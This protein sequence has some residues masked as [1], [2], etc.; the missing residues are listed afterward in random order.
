MISKEK[1]I[2]N[3]HIQ[4]IKCV[5]WDL[6]HTLW[7][8]VILE[9]KEVSLRCGIKEI[10]EQLDQRGI[11]QSIASKNDQKLVMEKLKELQIDQ[12]FLFPEI[13]WS[14]KSDSIKRIVKNLNIGIDTIAFID[15][16]EYE[17]EEVKYNL[18][19]VLCINAAKT[20][21][22]L[23][24]EEFIPRFI[25]VDSKKRRT[26]YIEDIKR[27][28]SEEEYAGPK[29]DFIKSLDMVLQLD[30]AEKS[31]LQRVEELT[32]RTNQLNATGTIYSYERLLTYCGSDSFMLLIASLQDKFGEYGKI[33]VSLIEI[34]DDVWILKMH[35]MSCRVMSRG[36]GTIILNHILSLAKEKGVRLLAEFIP[37]ERNRI[38]LLT[39]KMLHFVE[40]DRK[41]DTVILENYLDHITPTADYIKFYFNGDLVV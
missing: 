7:N 16:Q 20:E 19:Q 14:A 24:M 23:E 31:D 2:N 9:D 25:T 22:I 12:Y 41:D 13:C 11:L 8:G 37:N 39:Y 30:Y 1:L 3:D 36:V 33:G 6:D 5:V 35:L 32:I 27:K 10:I 38:M 40:I 28:K 29:I 26:M 21:R 15:D 34:H 18:P 17:L 4:K